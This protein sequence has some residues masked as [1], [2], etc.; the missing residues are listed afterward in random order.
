MIG[1]LGCEK[2]STFYKAISRIELP[3]NIVYVDSIVRFKNHSDSVNVTYKW[4]F[5]D[6]TIS[7]KRLVNHIYRNY[8]NYTVSLITYVDNIPTDTSTVNIKV[9]IG[10]K[11]FDMKKLT[12]GIDFVECSDSSIL[13]IGATRDNDSDQE[14]KMFLSKLDK[15]LRNKWTKYLDSKLNPAIGSIERL[16]DGNFILSGSF[17]NTNNNGYFALSKI[18]SSGNV[19]WDYKYSQ[20]KGYCRYA[21]ESKDGGIVAIGKEGYLHTSSGNT[22]QIVSVMKTDANGKFEWK[23]QFVDDWLMEAANIVSV[24][25]GFIFASSTR[26][27][28]NIILN[29]LD[30]LV[31]TKIG[32]DNH[33][34]WKKSKEWQISYSYIY[35]VFSSYIGLNNN[36][37]VAVNDGNGFVMVFDL[38]GN[39]IKRNQLGD[40]NGKNRF[41]AT[42]KDNGFIIGGGATYWD[43]IAL[44]GFDNSGIEKWSKSY[45]TRDTRCWPSYGFG[46]KVKPLQDGNLLFL[47]SS[48]KPCSDFFRSSM[49]LFKTNG[50][51]EIQ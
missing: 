20:A 4:N 44:T 1:L 17:N 42:T 7:D 13:L 23:R 31:I 45:G 30:S 26:G 39:F 2:E 29:D 3:S 51:G 28:N 19:L 10:E 14:S 21:T 33:T 22:V 8:G 6:G 50:N 24:D 12:D 46:S 40:G 47:G 48:Y 43:G 16:S 5:G 37:L 27:V 32:F 15:N 38:Q 35:N 25:D 41:I 18:D 34:I 36:K 49:L 9:M 11:Y